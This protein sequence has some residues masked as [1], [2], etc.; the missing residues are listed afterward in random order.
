MPKFSLNRAKF[1]SGDYVLMEHWSG[2]GQSCGQIRHVKLSSY[3]NDEYV[4][5]IYNFEC[6]SFFWQYESN[7]EAISD[8][9]AVLELM[10]I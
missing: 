6:R 4:C 9:Q 7:L 1:K 10:K 2:S 3:R 8:D 5:E